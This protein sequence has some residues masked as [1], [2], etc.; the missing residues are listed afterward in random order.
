M[1]L[2][3]IALVF[4]FAYPAA[5]EFP[6]LNRLPADQK[7]LSRA[8]ITEL[9]QN[10]AREHNLAPAFVKSIVAAESAFQTDAVSSKGALGLMQVMPETAEEMGLDASIPAENVEAGT[11]YLAALVGHYRKTTAAGYATPLQPILRARKCR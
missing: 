5:R 6:P 11:I 4:C 2:F 3:V 1:R 8:Q 9:I 7:P 10:A